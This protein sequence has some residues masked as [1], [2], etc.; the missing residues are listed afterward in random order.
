MDS[1]VLLD[2]GGFAY[3]TWPG[4]QVLR[5]VLRERM[6]AWVEAGAAHVV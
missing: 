5:T 2:Q 3:Y 4:S 6:T 1:S